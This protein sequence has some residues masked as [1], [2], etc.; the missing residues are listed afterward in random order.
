MR[1]P[2]RSAVR[3]PIG[4][5][6]TMQ[7]AGAVLPVCVALM[8]RPIDQACRNR[9]RM[10]EAP[11]AKPWNHE[12]CASKAAIWTAGSSLVERSGAELVAV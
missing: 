11:V 8:R 9:T 4:A 1:S 2:R 6:Q 12:V 3:S 7:E 5:S 10:C